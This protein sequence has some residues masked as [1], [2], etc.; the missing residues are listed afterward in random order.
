MHAGI[1]ITVLMLAIIS[2]YYNN[3]LYYYYYILTYDLTAHPHCI[4]FKLN[5]LN[6]FNSE[7]MFEIGR[8][9]NSVQL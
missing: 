6:Y 1:C 4:V 5:K 8:V 7:T 2:N 3:I 9:V